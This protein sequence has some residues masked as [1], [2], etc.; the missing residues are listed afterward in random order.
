MATHSA[1]PRTAISLFYVIDL[2]QVPQEF[3]AESTGFVGIIVSVIEIIDDPTGEVTPGQNTGGLQHVHGTM[4]EIGEAPIG[5]EVLQMD[6]AHPVTIAPECGR[7][8][9][10]AKRKLSGI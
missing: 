2:Q 1:E 5:G 3:Q 9:K 8:I 7:N 10:S 6:V 4:P